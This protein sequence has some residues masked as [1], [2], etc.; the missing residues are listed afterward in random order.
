MAGKKGEWKLLKT[1][2]TLG[3]MVKILTSSIVI[4]RMVASRISPYTLK[5]SRMRA[6]ET[7]MP[8][9][10]ANFTKMVAAVWSAVFSDFTGW[11]R[12]AAHRILQ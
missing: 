5:C 8:V 11:L 7:M 4:V 2:S 10:E 12:L 6:S 9:W 3:T 1:E